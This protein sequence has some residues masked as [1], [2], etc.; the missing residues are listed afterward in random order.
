MEYETLI[1]EKS[2]LERA[3]N[4]VND[5]LMTSNDEK[6]QMSKLYTD[7]K[8]KYDKLMFERNSYQHKLTETIT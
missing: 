5:L 2:D 8:Q 4:D 1:Q 3:L 7:L 6:F